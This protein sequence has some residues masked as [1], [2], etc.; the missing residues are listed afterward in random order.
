M[1]TIAYRDGTIAYD[2]RSTMGVVI[3]SN[4][5]EK[6]IEQRGAVFFCAGSESEFQ[7]L[8][9]AY[10]GK[11]ITAAIDAGALV[12]HKATGKLHTCGYDRHNDNGYWIAP[13]D[14]QYSF[15][16]GTGSPYAMTAMDMGA[17]AKKAVRMAKLRDVYTGGKVRTYTLPAR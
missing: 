5:I 6:K 7:I 3:Y 16:M 1:T 13:L 11:P 10:F 4:K 15:A 17:S 12:Y 8:I 2:S 9:D 14:P